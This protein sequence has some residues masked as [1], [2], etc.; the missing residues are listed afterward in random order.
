MTSIGRSYRCV[1]LGPHHR[2]LAK[3]DV[4]ANMK[5]HSGGSSILVTAKPVRSLARSTL[6]SERQQDAFDLDCGENRD[7]GPHRSSDRKRRRSD[8]LALRLQGVFSRQKLDH[9]R[10]VGPHFFNGLALGVRTR[11]TWSTTHQQARRKVAFNDGIEVHTRKDTERTAIDQGLALD[12]SH[13][14]TPNGEQDDLFVSGTRSILPITEI[15]AHPPSPCTGN[16]AGE[17]LLTMLFSA[18]TLAST[19]SSE[20]TSPKIIPAIAS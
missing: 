19:A 20:G 15:V 18:S 6:K 13:Q 9:F 17:A 3:T 2:K 4:A 8:E 11:N 1:L 14:A 7:S 12:R 16:A 5:R 10:K